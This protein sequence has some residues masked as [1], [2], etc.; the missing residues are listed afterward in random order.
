MDTAKPSAET[1]CARMP[2]LS[3][4]VQES[5][6]S[7]DVFIVTEQRLRPVL[8]RRG[9][10]GKDL[11]IS[12]GATRTELDRGLETAEVLL[13][14]NFASENLVQRAPRLKWIQSIFA[15]VEKLVPAIPDHIMLTNGSGVHTEKAGEF[16][17]GAIILLNNALLTLMANQR[18]KQWQPVFTSGLAGKT[19]VFLGTGKLAA[20]MARHCRD[21]GMHTI[22][23]NRQ[24]RPTPLFD[25]VFPIDAL[26][27][28][29]SRADFLVVA[30]PNTPA[31]QHLVAAPEF[32]CLPP[33]AGLVSIGRGQVIAEKDL[34]VA[35]ASGHLSGAV[36]DVFEVEPLPS[37]SPLW[38]M[39]NVVITPHC[40]VDDLSGYLVRA[41]DIFFNNVERYL[42]GRPLENLID[43]RHGY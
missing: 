25:A 24:G 27:Q 10:L 30:L 15:G 12:Y 28:A 5:A 34:A 11:E 39:E 13:V 31:T 26:H 41:L 8:E 37:D 20:D 36:L 33:G 4:H 3:V 23:V 21:F 38:T 16:G 35:L 2:P 18:R 19:V 32:A 6:G 22:G 9:H 43:L 1:S 29:L 42:S 7:L 17:I 40:C 14:G